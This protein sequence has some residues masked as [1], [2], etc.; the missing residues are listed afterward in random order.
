MNFSQIAY[1][2]FTIVLALVMAGIIIYYF[3]PKRKKK[4]EEPKYRILEEDDKNEHND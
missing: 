4:V 2:A 3:N 1:V